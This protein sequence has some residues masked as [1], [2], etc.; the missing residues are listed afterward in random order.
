M[1]MGPLAPFASELEARL[2]GQYGPT[3]LTPA[4]VR[5]AANRGGFITIA[6]IV[7]FNTG[8]WVPVDAQIHVGD[9]DWLFRLHQ[10]RFDL[11]WKLDEAARER[12][13]RAT[14][15]RVCAVR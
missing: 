11:D 1:D 5:F 10:N 6:K 8:R 15:R 14:E 2:A 7:D 3:M 9:M 13:G 12:A 4:D